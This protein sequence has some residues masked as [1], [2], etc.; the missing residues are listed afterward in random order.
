VAAA[1]GLAREVERVT[2]YEDLGVYRL[3]AANGD[4][5]ELDHFVQRWLGP[6]IEYDKTHHSELVRSLAEYLER[7][8]ALDQAAESLF[9]HRSTLKYRLGRVADLAGVDLSD[10]DTRFNLQLATRTLA[11]VGALAT[12]SSEGV[13]EEV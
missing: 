1:L 7:G 9:I 13:P 12:S 2:R 10:P 8:G 3:L 5:T 6:V 11:T 4:T